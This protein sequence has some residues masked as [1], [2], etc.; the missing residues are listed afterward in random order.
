MSIERSF[1][2][3]WIPAEIWLEKS[4]TV[5]EKLFL[6]EINSLDNNNGFFVS[7]GYFSKYFGISKNMC[8]KII[9]SLKAKGVI[10]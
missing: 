1:K 9:Q 5:M 2:G 3:I 6:V 4:L 10:P 8:S 7:N